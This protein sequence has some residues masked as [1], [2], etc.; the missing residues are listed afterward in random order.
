MQTRIQIEQFKNVQGKRENY[1]TLDLEKYNRK[2]QIFRIENISRKEWNET[3][4][5]LQL[6]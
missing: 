6:Y 3:I 5:K 4:E 1:S 2:I